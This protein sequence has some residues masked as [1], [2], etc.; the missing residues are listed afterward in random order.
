MK[1]VCSV[2]FVLT[3]R[4]TYSNKLCLKCKF[5]ELDPMLNST[6]G[7]H[8]RFRR[9]KEISKFNNSPTVN[10]SSALYESG[11]FES[12]DLSCSEKL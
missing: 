7:R 6:R 11:F 1:G 4:D 9:W 5:P 2:S 10:R 3:I 12:R 8:A